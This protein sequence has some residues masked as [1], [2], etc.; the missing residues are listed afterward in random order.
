MN[1][2]T[3]PISYADISIFSPEI[4]KFCYF[5]KY[6]YRLH[7]NGQFL[8]LLTLFESLNIVLINMVTTLMMSEKLVTLNL[9]KKKDILK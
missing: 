9:L 2:A 6:W 8:I 7:L 5:K 3:Y 1:H 4:S